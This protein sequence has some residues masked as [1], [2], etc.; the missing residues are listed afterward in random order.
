MEDLHFYIISLKTRTDRRRRMIGRIINMGLNMKYV[1]FIDATT[2]DD[3][4]GRTKFDMNELDI[5]GSK[6][7]H[8]TGCL[9]SHIR[10]LK[11]IKDGGNDMGV[12][13]EDDVMF[14]KNFPNILQS[15]KQQKLP[16]V[17]LGWSYVHAPYSQNISLVKNTSEDW[18]TQGYLVTKE[19]AAK[20]YEM[21]Y[22]DVYTEKAKTSEKITKGKENY[23]V[24]PP[25]LIEEPFC[26]SNIRDTNSYNYNWI[27][28]RRWGIENY[29]A[30]EDQYF[31]ILYG[32]MMTNNK[33]EFNNLRKIV[34]GK[35]LGESIQNYITSKGKILN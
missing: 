2:I 7:G 25:I 33:T 15:L 3:L 8:I 26:M 27:S 28:N 23:K 11:L 10:A 13:L 30:Y 19:F 6:L 9:D 21:H 1:H 35:D 17:L 12:V 31:Y 16:C 4:K 22:E 29:T 34:E 18:G 24:V 14:M 32:M 5:C 20:M